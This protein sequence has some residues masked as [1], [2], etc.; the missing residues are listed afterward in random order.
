MS[1]VPDGGVDC[2]IHLFGNV[3]RYRRWG[4]ARTRVLLQR[5]YPLVDDLLAAPGTSSTLS[6]PPIYLPV[7]GT[8]LGGYGVNCSRRSKL[9]DDFVICWPRPLITNKIFRTP[10]DVPGTGMLIVIEQKL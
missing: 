5:S 9:R 7:V 6:S 4:T 3:T 8:T 2:H 10:V 1:N